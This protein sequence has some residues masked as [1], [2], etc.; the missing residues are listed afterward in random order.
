MPP[1]QRDFVED[2]A[3]RWSAGVATLPGF[4]AA[5]FM[6]DDDAGEYGLYS[7]WQTRADAES[8]PE[9]LGPSSI[10]DRLEKMATTI[11]IKIF[12]V[13]EPRAFAAT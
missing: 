3:E 1:G 12:E 4:V 13:Y 5:Q 2:V 7:L 6:I 11:S 9:H 8:V 10:R